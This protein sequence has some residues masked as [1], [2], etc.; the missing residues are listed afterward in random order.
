MR[1]RPLRLPVNKFEV[2]SGFRFLVSQMGGWALVD[3]DR[4]RQDFVGRCSTHVHSVPDDLTRGAPRC[5][6][7]ASALRVW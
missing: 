6:A 4:M 1:K 3:V 2:A 7:E 5:T